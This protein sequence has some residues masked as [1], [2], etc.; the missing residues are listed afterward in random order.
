MGRQKSHS[1]KTTGADPHENSH[2]AVR[3]HL[4]FLPGFSHPGSGWHR[5]FG[6]PCC[7]CYSGK[8]LTLEPA[9]LDPAL[10]LN[11]LTV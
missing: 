5:A 3:W 11:I 9:D 7:R 8:P 2:S 10:V 1:A 6:V 4:A